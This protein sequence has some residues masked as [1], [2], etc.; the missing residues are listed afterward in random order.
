MVLCDHHHG[1]SFSF[2]SRARASTRTRRV[3]KIT[4]WAQWRQYH[5]ERVQQIAYPACA[6]L[7][8]DLQHQRKGV[9]SQMRFDIWD[10]Q[11]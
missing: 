8:P 4:F 2:V 5:H 1:R 3:T 7:D 6:N 9:M 10:R 11:Q